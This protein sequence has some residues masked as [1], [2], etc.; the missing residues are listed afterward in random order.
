VSEVPLEDRVRCE[1][2]ES[3][4]SLLRCYAA[5]AGTEYTVESASEWATVE[6]SGRAIRFSFDPRTGQAALREIF[7]GAEFAQ[8]FHIHQD[9]SFQIEGENKPIDMAAID[10]IARL[11][12]E[13]FFPLPESDLE[14]SHELT[15]RDNL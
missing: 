14:S 5:A 7:P 11:Q 9:G 13:P 2:W 4:I 10:W 15:D 1:I 8:E 6:R 3:F 12:K